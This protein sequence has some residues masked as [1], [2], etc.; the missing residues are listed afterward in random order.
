MSNKRKAAP[1]IVLKAADRNKELLHLTPCEDR[2]KSELIQK[3]TQQGKRISDCL[4]IYTQQGKT[5]MQI[6]IETRIER[7]NVCRRVAELR[8]KGEIWR[9]GKHIDPLTKCAAE[10][11]TSNE[12]TAREYYL[13]I[14]RTL[15]IG[16]DTTTKIAMQN[17]ISEYAIE[18]QGQIVGAR[19][20]TTNSRAVWD[21]IKAILDEEGAL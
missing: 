1:A 10:F 16:L 15:W 3:I 14:T 7:A 12:A 13:A 5:R 20:C 21:K 19:F 11:L 4:A 17:A 8:K 18:R 9:L 2:D 6:A